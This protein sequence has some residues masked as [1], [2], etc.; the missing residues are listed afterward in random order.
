MS[1]DRVRCICLYLS[2]TIV[3]LAL[4]GC[5]NGVERD[6][7]PYS[8]HYHVV[9]AGGAAPARRLVSDACMT[10]DVASDPLYLPPGCANA[11]NLQKMV[12]RERD[13]V[14]GRRTGA[15]MAATVVRPARR[16]ID[17]TIPVSP[18]VENDL[19]TTVLTD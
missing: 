2:A 3:L 12:E 13:L 8:P 16:L 6:P 17:G 19:D 9:G 5:Q 18:E 4:V 1:N 11:F 10:P 15:A 7:L 14:Q